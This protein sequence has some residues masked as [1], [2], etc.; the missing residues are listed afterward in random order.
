MF[1][2]SEAVTAIDPTAAWNAVLAHDRRFD[3]RFVYAVTSTG[4]FCR[5]SCPSRRPRPDRVQFYASPVEAQAAG[6][7][8]CRRCQPLEAGLGDDRRVRIVRE[9]IEQHADEPVTLARLARL[10]RTSPQRLQRSFRQ[11]MGVT[12]KAYMTARRL[13]RL[14][15]SLRSGASVADATYEAGFGSG[16]RVY[17]HSND[18][19]GM[20]PGTYRRGGQGARIQF[21]TIACSLGHMLVGATEKGVCRVAFGPSARDLERE[22]KAEYPAAE[23]CGG[24]GRF[25]AWVRAIVEQVDHGGPGD[26]VPVDVKGTAF[27][28]RVWGALRQ[29]PLGATRSYAEIA[30]AIGEPKAARAVAR[31]CAT[32]PVAVVVPCHRVV[33]GDGAPGGYR[34]GVQRKRQLL[35]TE[36]R[37]V[38]ARA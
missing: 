2:M 34:W 31:A 8:A 28:S 21:A 20:T 32:N 25:D 22:L 24:D 10:V 37:A 18:V 1:A 29:I 6:Y 35:E 7:R 36:Q 33:R 11:A 17:E 12:P 23:I 26:Q 13:E 38:R 3:G 19:L 16:S 27:Q 5:P 4:V 14:K 30:R 15:T 9:F